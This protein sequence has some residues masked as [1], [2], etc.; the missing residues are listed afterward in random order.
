MKKIAVVSIDNINNAG[1]EIIGNIARYLTEKISDDIVVKKISFCPSFRYLIKKGYVL[2]AVAAIVMLMF[3]K[4]MG[5]GTVKYKTKNIA[6]KFRFGKYYKTLLKNVDG[7]VCAVGMLKYSTQNHSYLYELLCST[8]QIYSIPVIFCGQSVE[9]FHKEDWRCRQLRHALNYPVVKAIATRDGNSGIKKLRRY[10]KR[11]IPVAGVGDLALWIPDY[12]NIE[13]K[14]GRVIGVGLVRGNIYQDYMP[15]SNINE[16]RLMNIYRD[17]VYELERRGFEWVFFCNG[18]KQD[19]NFGRQLLKK[20]NLPD[21]KLLRIP[22]CANELINDIAGFKGVIGA[23]FHACMVSF[24]IGIPFIGMV[25]DSKFSGVGKMMGIEEQFVEAE[26]LN[27]EYMVN[28]LENVLK[29]GTENRWRE[30]Y[31]MKTQDILHFFINNYVM[32]EE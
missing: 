28:L 19:Y 24:S 12:Y 11:N 15:E 1:D 23:R 7:I 20:M 32:A 8:A 31:K 10:V 17:I 25:W 9:K 5:N 2:Q 3:A 30:L 14:S 16:C 13:K 26:D 22:N 18:I 6:Y 4:L 27:G 29:K 21:N